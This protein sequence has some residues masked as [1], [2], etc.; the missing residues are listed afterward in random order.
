MILGI[1][2]IQTV[3]YRLEACDY[4]RTYSLSCGSLNTAGP[5]SRGATRET[6]VECKKRPG[7]R[8]FMALLW[9][10]KTEDDLLF[11]VCPECVTVAARGEWSV[12]ESESSADDGQRA[13]LPTLR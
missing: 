5:L 4:A 1:G 2:L 6:L 10:G 7:G 3:Q 13:T 12:A 8:R 9:V 11:A